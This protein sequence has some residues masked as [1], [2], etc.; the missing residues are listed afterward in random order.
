[1]TAKRSFLL[2]IGVFVAFLVCLYT[3]LFGIAA[4]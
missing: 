2:L 1:M 4:V 3:G